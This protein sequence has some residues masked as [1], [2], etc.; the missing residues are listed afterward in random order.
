M[1]QSIFL[2]SVGLL[3]L[4][5]GG[6]WLVV[7]AEGLA[8]RLHLPDMATAIVVSIGTAYPVV[9]LSSAAAV[10]GKSAI[11]YGSVVG[12]LIC[13]TALMAGIS[14]L[15]NPG[16]VQVKSLK[17]PA[18]FFFIAAALYC[19]TAYLLREFPR[20][21]GLAMVGIFV[22]FVILSRRYDLT[23]PDTAAVGRSGIPRTRPAELLLLG[24]GGSLAAVGAKLL[25]EHGSGTA[26][27]LG[28]PEI[29]LGL[30]LVPIGIFVPILTAVIVK[31]DPTVLRIGNIIRTNVCILTLAFGV[32][33]SLAPFEVPMGRLML[34]RNASLLL[35]IPVMLVA[36][37]LLVI[38][39]LIRKKLSR[40]QGIVLLC[41]YTTFCIL[42]YSSERRI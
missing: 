33:V 31:K 28:V 11:A 35:D 14:A 6:G 15:W 41:I 30:I 18:I 40:W 24:I 9:M 17:T 26:S 42:R 10:L 12:S 34:G 4:V 3:L 7:G 16:S 21:L 23:L 36:M 19:I 22:V 39:T 5:V 13:S 32:A 25:A 37:I 8:R 20:W 38:P 1:I 2:L 29:V 27:V